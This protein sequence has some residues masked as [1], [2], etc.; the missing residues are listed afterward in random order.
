MGCTNELEF[1]ESWNNLITDYNLQENKWFKKIYKVR[2]M[3]CTAF[4]KDFFSAGT[5]ATQRCESTNRAI[6]INATKTTSLT[7]FERL[8][9]KMVKNWR[10]TEQKYESYCIRY[11]P[12]S[13]KGGL[14]K[15]AAEVYTM[16]IY[17]AFK[18]EYEWAMTTTVVEAQYNN[19]GYIR[20]FDVT[21]ENDEKNS[22][23][24][25]LT[26]AADKSIELVCSCMRFQETG[27]LCY[28]MIRILHML[29][30]MRIPEQYIV[31]RWTKNVKR[32]IWDRYLE[33]GTTA[34]E[35]K[36]LKD[37]VPWRHKIT[38]Q[39][40]NLVVQSEDN[41]DARKLLEDAVKRETLLLQ[42]TLAI[43]A[44]ATEPNADSSSVTVED[45]EIDIED[46][47]KANTKGRRTR[48]KASIEQP[49][50]QSQNEFGSY[51]PK[52]TLF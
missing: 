14:L 24:V 39:F 31:S 42:R 12:R 29:S 9:E 4:S 3:W 26:T 33:Q 7:Q 28:H 1:E 25:M 32:Q 37:S 43:E 23:S 8:F 35:G 16:K 34:E 40:Y 13:A 20:S 15:H 22:G 2:N 38:A 46:P 11:F 41:L 27:L 48:K 36:K 19:G 49:K 6:S 45:G 30:I 5:L 50:K 44:A 17:E 18:K 10:K 21:L 52:P 47:K 51:T